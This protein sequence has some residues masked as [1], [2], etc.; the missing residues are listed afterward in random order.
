MNHLLTYGGC[1]QAIAQL[2]SNLVAGK[3]AQEVAVEAH[4]VIDGITASVSDAEVRGCLVI[5]AYGSGHRETVHHALSGMGLRISRL[6]GT[7]FSQGIAFAALFSLLDA[8]LPS[9]ELAI[10]PVAKT[11]AQRLAAE[12]TVLLLE[13]PELLDTSTVAVVSHLIASGNAKAVIIT[14]S[15][16]TVPAEL[17]ALTR[18]GLLRAL[19][20]EPL[21]RQQIARIVASLLECTPSVLAVEYLHRL[22]GGHLGWFLASLHSALDCGT[23]LPRGTALVLSDLPMQPAGPLRAMAAT[24]ASRLAEEVRN[25]LWEKVLPTPC[26]G[27]EDVPDRL[28]RELEFTGYLDSAGPAMAASNARL[29][30]L[31]ASLQP[32]GALARH[33]VLEI[34]PDADL[35]EVLPESHPLYR[36]TNRLHRFTEDLVSGAP[37]S[38]GTTEAALTNC[39]AVVSAGLGQGVLS[40]K[41]MPGVLKTLIEFHVVRGELRKLAELLEHLE[42][43]VVHSPHG[44]SLLEVMR[45]ALQLVDGGTDQA[46]AK[47]EVM[48]TQAQT[49]ESSPYGAAIHALHVG[50]GSRESAGSTARVTARGGLGIFDLTVELVALAVSSS[51]EAEIRLRI[52]ERLAAAR[53]DEVLQTAV[54]SILFSRGERAAALETISGCPEFLERLRPGLGLLAGGL[55]KNEDNVILRGIKLLEQCGVTMQREGLGNGLI[56]TLEEGGA[57]AELRIAAGAT[58]GETPSLYYP[59][60]ENLTKREREMVWEVCR[61]HSNTQIAQRYG[62]ST[63]TVEGH[64]YQIYAK[65]FV[66]HRQALKMLVHDSQIIEVDE[67]A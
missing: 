15:L 60:I 17:R 63:R 29:G 55:Q 18:S 67:S 43:L 50:V 19:E 59:G 2:D 54:Q 66:P 3:I 58:G 25:G 41:Q 65:I 49:L 45:V 40:C 31:L 44:M 26:N 11:V 47:L 28:L 27:P 16:A 5:G 48:A 8:D 7:T 57:R 61:G 23:L 32:E 21:T 46:R 42:P 10:G 24:L 12:P 53:E 35:H 6:V 52:L 37:R 51:K 39:V 9:E 13:R 38:P 34:T 62:I 56:R 30:L 22:S 1:A 33:Q 4:A 14:E 20:Q 64:L 36:A